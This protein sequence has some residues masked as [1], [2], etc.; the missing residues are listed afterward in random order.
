MKEQ[1]VVGV[2]GT[3]GMAS[4]YLDFSVP[5]ERRSYRLIA[6]T[7]KRISSATFPQPLLRRWEWL[8]AT[9]PF[10]KDTRRDSVCIH[11]SIFRKFWNIS[12]PHPSNGTPVLPR[13]AYAKIGSFSILYIRNDVMDSHFSPS[14]LGQTIEVHGHLWLI[15]LGF[16]FWLSAFKYYS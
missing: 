8:I 15:V 7:T 11:S 2:M 9:S 1:C 16:R 6:R 13:L 10:Q 3:D 14:I 12:C 4:P 5:W